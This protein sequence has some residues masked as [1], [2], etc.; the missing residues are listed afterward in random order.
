MNI[1][2]GRKTDIFTLPDDSL[3]YG[4]SFT[5][6]LSEIPNIKRF[7]LTQD[8]IDHFLLE[9]VVS[10]SF[11]KGDEEEIFSKI[12]EK[13]KN[14]VKVSI[15]YKKRIGKLKSGKYCFT[16]SMIKPKV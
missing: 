15:K 14:L 6:L 12:R 1:V 16:K 10:D 7:R 11:N 9:L 3:I 4:E 8:K 13:T 2:A 5:Q